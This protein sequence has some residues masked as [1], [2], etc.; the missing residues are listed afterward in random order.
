MPSRRSRWLTLENALLVARTLNELP[1][2]LN[3]W[4]A[5]NIWYDVWRHA[6]T[7]FDAQARVMDGKASMDWDELLQISV[8]ELV[9]DDET[10][11]RW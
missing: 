10:P 6:A 9:I 8:S 1:F 3:L 5:Q 2:D 11:T 7:G 4:Q